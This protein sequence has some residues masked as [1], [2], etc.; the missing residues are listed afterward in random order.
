MAT[1][2][3]ILVFHGFAICGAV[4]KLRCRQVHQ[5]PRLSWVPVV[6]CC[7]M[8]NKTVI[9]RQ[10]CAAVIAKGLIAST[11]AYRCGLAA[12]FRMD[13]SHQPAPILDRFI[14]GWPALDLVSRGYVSSHISRLSRWF[15]ETPPIGFVRQILSATHT[16]IP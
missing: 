2:P 13:A 9:I 10:A 12:R 14:L 8:P 4:V 1:V 11:L 7:A 16:I 5:A 15:H 3:A 6:F